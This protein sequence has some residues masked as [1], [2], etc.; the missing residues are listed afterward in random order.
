M[1]RMPDRVVGVY[2]SEPKAK[3]GNMPD[4]EGLHGLR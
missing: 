1:K 3:N 2:R 4:T